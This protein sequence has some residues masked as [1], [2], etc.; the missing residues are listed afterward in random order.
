[1]MQRIV[2]A[3]LK[4]RFLVV[5]LAAALMFIGFAQIQHSPVD[6]FPEFAQPRVEV[7]TLSVGLS[8]SEV[9]SLVTV[10]LEE[11]LNGVPGLDII[12]SKSAP[13]LSV[14]DMLFKPGPALLHARQWVQE[15]LNESSAQLPS[16]AAPPVMIQPLSSTSRVMK[17]GLTSK[18]LNLMQLSIMSYW[19]I[20]NRLLRVPGVANVPIWGE[21]LQLLQV[22]TDPEKLKAQQV[23]LEKVMDA[24]SLALDS[25]ILRFTNG[26]FVG[27]GGFL[28]TPQQRLNVRH[29]LPITSPA[30]LGQVVVDEREGQQLRLADV[31]TVQEGEPPLIGDAVINDGPGLMLIVEKLPWAN[32]LDVTRGVEQALKELQPGLSGVTVDPAIFRPAN[33][34]ERALHNLSRALLLGALLMV[35]MLFFFLWEWRVGRL[36]IIA[37]PP[38]LLIA[39]PPLPPPGPAHKNKIPPPPGVAPPPR[40]RD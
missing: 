12:R 16:W 33:F 34:I 27:T 31:A 7:Q 10:P 35:I 14:I 28:D 38:S 29:I 21:R 8:P 26:Q 40:L 13:Q 1:M 2:A 36:S 37:P 32:T 5:A 30:D 19:T 6:V 9:E 4:F 24:T 11:V 3:S 39:A 20:R 25:G 17:I 18:D 23:S 15:R 22:Q